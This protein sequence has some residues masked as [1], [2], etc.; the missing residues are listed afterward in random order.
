[1]VYY[2]MAAFLISQHNPCQIQVNFQVSKQIINIMLPNAFGFTFLHIN[3][4]WGTEVHWPVAS[5]VSLE[6]R[7]RRLRC[8][9]LRDT[10]VAIAKG[11]HLFL[12]SHF[13]LRKIHFCSRD[14][15]LKLSNT[16]FRGVGH[17]HLCWWSCHSGL[18]A[19]LC[20]SLCAF[21]WLA[22]FEDYRIYSSKMAWIFFKTGSITVLVFILPLPRRGV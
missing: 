11:L 15:V 6:N 21:L 8:W 14:T 2:S 18:Q 20:S 17:V 10:S 7:P 16:G 4:S 5:M 3:N 22:V 13:T 12:K 19:V 1:M 9:F